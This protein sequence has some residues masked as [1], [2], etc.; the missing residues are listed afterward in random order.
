ML[1]QKGGAVL[2]GRDREVLA[3]TEN[4]DVGRAQL[5]S[6]GR[7]LVDAD[8]PGHRHRRLLGQRPESLPHRLRHFLFCDDRLQ[9]SGS[10]PHDGEP[11]L[12]TRPGG[13]DP[14]ANRHHIVNVIPQISNAR[15]L[16]HWARIVALALVSVNAAG[17]A[18]R[19]LKA[20][21]H[22]PRI[23][24]QYLGTASRAPSARGVLAAELASLWSADMGKPAAGALAVGERVVAVMGFDRYLT[25]VDWETGQRLWRRRLNTTGAAGPMAAK[26]EFLL[27]IY[28]LLKSSCIHDY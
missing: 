4:R 10:I 12:A 21:A 3:L 1:E 17:C 24:T 5:D 18:P 25:L 6:S 14:C 11:D 7:A 8:D 26:A 28:D 15:M 2:L 20:P 19:G 22:D 23:W 13:R 27:I 16:G 9:V